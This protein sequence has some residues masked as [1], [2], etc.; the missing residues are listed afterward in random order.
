[1]LYERYSGDKNLIL[2]DGD[3]NSPRPGFYFDSVSIFFSNNLLIDADFNG[4]NA[5]PPEDP[6]E[7]VK[8]G[9]LF[10]DEIPL[11]LLE[12][13]HLSEIESQS[14]GQMRPSSLEEEEEQ[15]RKAILLSMQENSSNT[16][17]NQPEP[18]VNI[19][20]PNEK[21]PTNTKDHNNKKKK[22]KGK[23]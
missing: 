11:D 6:V 8:Y 9:K 14:K 1:M 16:K 2:F 5:I 15:I 19:A 20:N 17:P 13:I 7:E 3:H 12:Q 22:K 21:E 23:K 18:N 4:D 10:G